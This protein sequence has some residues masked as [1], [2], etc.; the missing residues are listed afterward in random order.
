MTEGTDSYDPH[1][2]QLVFSLQAGAMQHLGKIASPISGKIERDLNLAKTTIDMLE[3]L[4]KKTEGN[5]NNDE[6]RLIDHI[7]YELRMNYVDETKKGDSPEE[8]SS[9]E[10][11]EETQDEAE[12]EAASEDSS[13]AEKK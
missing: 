1:F 9:A 13:E 6:K 3:M 8:D 5:L 4:Q 2:F 7:L 12:A 11:N 10:E